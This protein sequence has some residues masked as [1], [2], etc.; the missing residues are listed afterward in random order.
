M[1][2]AREALTDEDLEGWND[3]S[4]AGWRDKQGVHIDAALLNCLICEIQ[5]W[6]RERP[7]DRFDSG[8]NTIE[9]K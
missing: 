5:A 8:P 4:A 6:R 2:R 3:A 7:L 1:N 9:P